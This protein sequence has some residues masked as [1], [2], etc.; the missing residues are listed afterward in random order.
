MLSYQKGGGTKCNKQISRVRRCNPWLQNKAF[1]S[2]QLQLMVRPHPHGSRSFLSEPGVAAPRGC[3]RTR[4]LGKAGSVG[5]DPGLW[6]RQIGESDSRICPMGAATHPALGLEAECDLDL[7]KKSLEPLVEHSAGPACRWGW[8]ITGQSVGATWASSRT[9]C[10]G[11]VPAAPANQV[12]GAQFPGGPFTCWP[13]SS[14][15]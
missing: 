14:R 1:P 13:S 7:G 11:T 2:G 4:G 15:F 6:Q 5:T 10:L 3:E 8:L 9:R 12:V